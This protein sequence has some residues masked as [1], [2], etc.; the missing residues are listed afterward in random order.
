MLIRFCQRG[1]PAST[2]LRDSILAETWRRSFGKKALKSLIRQAA[3]D[4]AIRGRRGDVPLP[5]HSAP[6]A[7]QALVRRLSTSL[8]A[9][10]GDR[11]I[12][13]AFV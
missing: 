7:R 13:E 1:F 4:L 11:T 8:V 2:K 9:A 3:P 12:A 5:F 6:R 10:Q